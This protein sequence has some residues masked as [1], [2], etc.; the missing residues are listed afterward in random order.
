MRSIQK[1]SY[2]PAV[3]LPLQQAPGTVAYGVLNP[4]VSIIGMRA[5]C[6]M[7]CVQVSCKELTEDLGD[8]GSALDMGVL[9]EGLSL[10]QGSWPLPRSA[11]HLE[12]TP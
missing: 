8:C 7:T 3:A 10:V 12:N 2:F 11:P 9:A 6:S 1:A 4:N 5:H